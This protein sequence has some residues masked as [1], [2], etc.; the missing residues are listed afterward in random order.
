MYVTTGSAG[1]AAIEAQKV[2]EDHIITIPGIP[3]WPVVEVTVCHSDRAMAQA[4]QTLRS[5]QAPTPA[6]PQE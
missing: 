3:N 5:L 6:T 2:F 1:E 4:Q